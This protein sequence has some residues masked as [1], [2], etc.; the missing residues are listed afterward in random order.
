VIENLYFNEDQ[1]ILD[2]VKAV[3]GRWCLSAET[4][5]MLRSVVKADED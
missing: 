5:D 4:A 3:D 1:D 2:A